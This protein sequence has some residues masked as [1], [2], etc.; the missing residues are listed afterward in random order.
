MS[1]GAFFQDLAMM[2]SVVGIVAGVFSRFKWPKVLGYLF[3]GI[4]LSEHT[5]GGSF[6]QDAQSVSTIGQ[7]GVVF[8]M[9]TMGLSFSA[10]DMKKIRSVALPCAVVDTLVMIW[11]GHTVGTRFFGWSSVQSF[12]LGVAIC[13]SATTLLAK[14]ID[15]MGWGRRQFTKYVLGTSV[16]EDIVCVGAISVATGFARVG[17]MSAGDLAASLGWLTVFLFAVLV[18][19]LILIPRLL[20]SVSRTKDDEALILTILGTCFFISYFAYTFNFSLALGAFLVGIIG[21]SSV[22]RDRITRLIDPLKAMFS[23]VFFVSIGLL[24]DP[25]ALMRYAPQILLV[26]AVVVGGKLFNNTVAAL[27]VG[28]DVKTAVQTGF[29]LAQIGEFAFMVALLYA[30]LVDDTGNPMFQIAVGASLATTLLNPWMVRISDPVGTFVERRLPNRFRRFL[31]NYQAWLAK[32]GASKGSPAF[33]LLKAAAIRLG[34]YA[35]LMIAISAGCTLLYRVDYSRLSMTFERYDQPIFFLLA[36]FLSL[37]LLPLVIASARS[38]GDEVAAM[39]CDDSNSRW[40]A[41][42]RQLVRLISVLA[43]LA[44]FFLLW[45]MINVAIMP[46][47]WVQWVSIAVILVTGTVG[48]RFFRKAGRRATDRFHEALTAE[49]RLAGLAKTITVTVPDGAY[50]RI[51]LTAASPAIGKT[52]AMLNVRAQTGASVVSVIRNGTTYRNIGPS[53]TF[54]VGDT[55]IAVGESEQIAALCKLLHVRTA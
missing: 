30:G 34:V 27:A 6:L 16:C 48:W 38:L 36:N 15:E 49:E 21:A 20:A 11:I 47:G 1:E 50:Q 55:L 23:A 10:R 19:G 3:A 4:I 8:L 22:V 35:V 26:S 14:V 53:W 29:S 5:W 44:L 12:F 42:V 18:F 37:A 28:V 33:I 7:L 13:D 46:G 31:S 41:A 17:K 40:Q 45:T 2:M 25:V 9:L 52:V 51:V 32:I 39:L 24:V 43:V 54:D